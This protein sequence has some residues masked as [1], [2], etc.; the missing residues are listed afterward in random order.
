M[1]WHHVGWRRSATGEQME[2]FHLLTEKMSVELEPR[3][4]SSEQPTQA[5]HVS[6]DKITRAH[7]Y[8]DQTAHWSQAQSEIMATIENKVIAAMVIGPLNNRTYCAWSAF[9]LLGLW[10]KLYNCSLH[11]FK[12]CQCVLRCAL[13]TVS[14]TSKKLAKIWKGD[15][16]THPPVWEVR[17]GHGGWGWGHSI[18]HPTPIIMI[19]IKIYYAHSGFLLAPQWHIWSIS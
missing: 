13:L 5:L 18:A 3:K 2:Q 17:E 19:M 7:L 16:Y 15:F 6:T 10:W 12:T 14:S 4:S 11:H 8:S 1:D 9:T